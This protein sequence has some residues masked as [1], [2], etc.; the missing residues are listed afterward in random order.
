M[1]NA[2]TLFYTWNKNLHRMD[3]DRNKKIYAYDF[4]NIYFHY[5]RQSRRDERIWDDETTESDIQYS[6]RNSG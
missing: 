3:L 2:I 6:R 1:Y 5:R 4:S